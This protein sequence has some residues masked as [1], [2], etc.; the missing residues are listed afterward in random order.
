MVYRDLPVDMARQIFDELREQ[1]KVPDD[2]KPIVPTKP[3]LRIL[4]KGK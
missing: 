3:K 1:K 4:T 2:T